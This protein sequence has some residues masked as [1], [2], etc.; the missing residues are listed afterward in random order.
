MTEPEWPKRYDAGL[1]SLENKEPTPEEFR[2]YVSEK[3][4]SQASDEQLKRVIRLTK[5]PALDAE[6]ICQYG[7]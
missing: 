6:H 4:G 5:F 1:V 2:G 7:Y 3:L